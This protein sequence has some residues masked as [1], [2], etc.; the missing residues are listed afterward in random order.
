[1]LKPQTRNYI[2]FLRFQDQAI[3][4]GNLNI[5]ISGGKL[6]GN[7]ADYTENG[8][9]YW[10]DLRDNDPT[11]NEFRVTLSE[12]LCLTQNYFLIAVIG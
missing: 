6:L 9:A 2:S 7:N 1:M 12:S 10:Y 8:T 3:W 4:I 5:S 11:E